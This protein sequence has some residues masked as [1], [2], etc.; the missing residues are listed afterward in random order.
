MLLSESADKVTLKSSQHLPSILIFKGLPGSSVIKSP[1][2]DA[3][4]AGNMGSAAELG[5]A[6]GEAKGNPFQDSRLGN[7]K[8]RGAWK[9]IV[10]RVAK[11]WDTAELLRRKI[12]GPREGRGRQDPRTQGNFGKISESKPHHTPHTHPPQGHH[13]T[14]CTTR[15]PPPRAAPRRSPS[16]GHQAEGAGVFRGSSPAPSPAQGSQVCCVGWLQLSATEDRCYRSSDSSHR[17]LVQR[18]ISRVPLKLANS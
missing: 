16:P 18:V 7:P 8:G 3:E 10:H 1:P 5:R 14:L 17:G 4:D 2:A 9:A 13:V 11:D 15:L 12:R 6:L